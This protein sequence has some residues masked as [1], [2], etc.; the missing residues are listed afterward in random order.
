MHT[1]VI[2]EWSNA[3]NGVPSK[4]ARGMLSINLHVETRRR[5]S[6]Y[7]WVFS[8][9]H[10]CLV[11]S[12]ADRGKE[13]GN[14]PSAVGIK[15]RTCIR[16]GHASPSESC[17]WDCIVRV[18]GL[19]MMEMLYKGPCMH[20][21]AVY[22]LG[23][24]WRWRRIFDSTGIVDD[25]SMDS[26]CFGVFARQD[27]Q[28]FLWDLVTFWLCRFGPCCQLEEIEPECLPWIIV[29][30]VYVHLG[31]LLMIIHLSVVFASLIRA[32]Q[33]FTGYSV[34]YGGGQTD[35]RFCT[36]AVVAR[37]CCRPCH[38]SFGPVACKVSL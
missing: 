9:T 18:R 32:E 13:N 23:E 21:I 38:E 29:E 26:S 36:C 7:A 34:V 37:W 30:S 20:R 35:A 14:V 27:V 6:S 3:K 19:Y 17:A 16:V 15:P 4:S 24:D 5:S 12:S 10:G 25:M 8:R 33:S 2:L 31:P 11:Q 22:E 28:Y 1:S